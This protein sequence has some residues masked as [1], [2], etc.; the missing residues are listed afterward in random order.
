MIFETAFHPPAW[1]ITKCTGK[2]W[3]LNKMAGQVEEVEEVSI[4]SVA[5]NLSNN[6]AVLNV[7][8]EKLRSSKKPTGWNS[9][10]KTVAVSIAFE[11][12]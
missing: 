11:L 9:F 1:E 4:E 6:P 8:P 2:F 5:P 7:K 12:L 10:L 3:E